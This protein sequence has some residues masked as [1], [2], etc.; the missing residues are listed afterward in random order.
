M[1]GG[2]AA[3]SALPDW[4]SLSAKLDADATASGEAFDA[5]ISRRVARATADESPA[6]SW[7]QLSHRIDTM[8]PLRRRL[9]RYRVLEMAAVILLLLT[10]G[11]ML[12]DRFAAA[13]EG[14]A[15]LAEAAPEPDGVNGRPSG[16]VAVVPAPP[17]VG[18]PADVDGG[19]YSPVDNLLGALGLRDVSEDVR[20]A[21]EI[22][23]LFGAGRAEVGGRGPALQPPTAERASTFSLSGFEAPGLSALAILEDPTRSAEVYVA[24]P[25]GALAA[26]PPVAPR[27]AIPTLTAAAKS[28]SF[29]ASGTF[30]TWRIATP[31]DVAFERAGSTRQATASQFGAHVLYDIS[32]KWRLGLSLATA[33]ATY[34]TGLPEIRRRAVVTQAGYDISEDFRS[35]DLDVAQTT[36]DARY[37]LLP[38]GRALQVWAKAGLGANAFLRTA[39]EVRREDLVARSMQAS[40]NLTGVEEFSAKPAV[41]RSFVPTQQ[42]DFT[43]GL[44]Q[45]G[46][47]TDNTQFFGRLGV[48]T[49]LKLGDRLRAFG[50]FDYDAALPGQEGF[51]PNRDRFGGY[52]VAL[53]ARISL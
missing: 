8:W 28:W 22:A 37:A 18:A 5:L 3:G 44:L 11:P 10:F 52:G 14:G 47:L 9:K 13:G 35:I 20:S 33:S 36:L 4:D 46:S 30:K 45:G 1:A 27:L 53:G 21:E 24:L 19:A 17:S 48:E 29:G 41:E 50:A 42:K 40:P 32:A 34:A 16:G 26:L 25:A 23:A 2:S 49:E 43:E 39:Y 51:G 7:R 15:V 12:R 6:A 31:T 38:T